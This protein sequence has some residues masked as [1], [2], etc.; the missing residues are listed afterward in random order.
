MPLSHTLAKKRYTAR[1]LNAGKQNNALGKE[2]Q[3][4]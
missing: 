1:F 3:Y 4:A 2:K